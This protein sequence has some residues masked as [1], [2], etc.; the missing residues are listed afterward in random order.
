MKKTPR[1]LRNLTRIVVGGQKGWQVKINRRGERHEP[2]FSDS[3]YGGKQQAL[4]AAMK[5]RDKLD[6]QCPPFTRMERAQRVTR[7]TKS[8]VPGVR[9]LEV[10][11]RLG[12]RKRTY[13]FAIA[14]WCPRPGVIKRRAFSVAKFGRRKAWEKAVAARQ[15][16]LRAMKP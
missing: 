2:Y 10:H 11:R 5:A 3:V 16:G 12:R 14:S 15:E 7:R 13:L 8:G 6:R 1:R 9:L 4:A